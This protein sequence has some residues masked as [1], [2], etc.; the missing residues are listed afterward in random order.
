MSLMRRALLA[1][2]TNEWLRRQATKQRFVRSAVSRFMPGET[3]DD[4]LRAAAELGRERLDTIVTQLGENV[5]DRSEAMAVLEHYRAVLARLPAT[6]L[7]TEVSVKLTQL[8]LD[9]DPE[10]AVANTIDLAR[11]S[12]AIGRRL[13]ID[14]EASNYVER[15][16]D[17]YRKVLAH[18]KLVGVALQAYLHRTAADLESLIPLGC[19]IRMVKGAYQEPPEVAMPKKADVDESFFRLSARLLDDDAR[20]AG[21]HVTIATHDRNL[22][23]RLI[24]AAGQRG[25]GKD[26]Y[27]FAM[28]Y[29]I[30]R[31][32]QQRLVAAGHRTRVLISYGASWFP[33]YMRR[34]AERPANVWFVVKSLAG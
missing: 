25:V 3:I 24:A 26:G 12:A 17:V 1:G 16:L 9:L 4:A 27:E 29:G 15:T 33:W 18:E 6:G 21:C 23:G 28:L 8:G 14:M 2:S 30:Q 34:L 31:A 11:R 32:E 13:W 19:A 7:D 22:I 20:R 10:L 5:T